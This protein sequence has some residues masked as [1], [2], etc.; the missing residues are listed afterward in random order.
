V[1]II[2][3]TAGKDQ[4]IGEMDLSAAKMQLY[5][6]AIYIHMGEQF[7]VQRL[8]LEN[9]KAFVEEVSV[10]YYTDSIVKSDIKILQDPSRRS[11]R[12]AAWRL[13]QDCRHP[14]P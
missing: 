3:T 2:N 8:D 14:C 9:R 10:N 5:D 12:S 7:V 13:P 11:H 1:I 6:N 4:V